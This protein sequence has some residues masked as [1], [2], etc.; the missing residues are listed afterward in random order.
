MK[1]NGPHARG[2]M[3]KAW[4]AVNSRSRFVRSATLSNENENRPGWPYFRSSHNQKPIKP[5]AYCLQ[6]SLCCPLRLWWPPNGLAPRNIRVDNHSGSLSGPKS[7]YCIIGSPSISSIS[8]RRTLWSRGSN[9]DTHWQSLGSKIG[10]HMHIQVEIRPKVIGFC[11]FM[12]S[13]CSKT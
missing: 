7:A 10:P 11:E 12:S 13:S 9:R 6:L 8:G 1:E 4:L 5:C 2:R 3:H